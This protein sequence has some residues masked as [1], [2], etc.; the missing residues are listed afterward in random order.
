MRR[1]APAGAQRTGEPHA[2]LVSDCIFCAIVERRAEGSFVHEDADVVAV[3]DLTP[4]NDGHVLVMPRAHLPQL[5]DLSP[6]LAGHVV[7]VAQRV[8]AALRRSGVPCE[9]VNLFLAD[10][11][12]ASQEVM[13]AHLHVF[14]RYAGDG[15]RIEADWRVRPRAE[16]DAVAA[17]LRRALSAS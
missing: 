10:G 17:D 13:H 2:A 7:Q 3:M 16:L 1:S 4:V 14:P 6:D 8:A 15:F 5:A 9:G 11:E 12:A